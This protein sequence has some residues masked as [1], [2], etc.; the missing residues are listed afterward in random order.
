MPLCEI[1]LAVLAAVLTSIPPVGRENM[2][3]KCES[4]DE[5]WIVKIFARLVA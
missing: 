3:V 5:E 1:A 4:A 2:R